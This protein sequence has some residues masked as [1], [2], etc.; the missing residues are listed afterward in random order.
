M[1]KGP[2]HLELPSR[3]VY[4]WREKGKIVDYCPG[5]LGSSRSLAFCF[6]LGFILEARVLGYFL[7]IGTTVFDLDIF[8]RGFDPEAGFPFVPSFIYRS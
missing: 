8:T 7:S 1:P 6:R 2:C 3:S 4:Q 5:E